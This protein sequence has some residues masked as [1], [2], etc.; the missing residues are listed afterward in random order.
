MNLT[1]STIPINYATLL[2]LNLKTKINISISFLLESLK[3][4][5]RKFFTAESDKFLKIANVTVIFLILNAVC[6]SIPVL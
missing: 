5:S 6:V 3:I 2:S 4:H 1:I